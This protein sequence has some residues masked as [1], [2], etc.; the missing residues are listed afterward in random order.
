MRLEKLWGR[1]TERG[2]TNSWKTRQLWSKEKLLLSKIVQENASEKNESYWTDGQNTALSCTITRLTKLPVRWLLGFVLWSCPEVRAGLKLSPFMCLCASRNLTG[3]T[4]I[5][6]CRLFLSLVVWSWFQLSA[7]RWE[8]VVICFHRRTFELC[9][10]CIGHN[11]Y[12]V[13]LCKWYVYPD[14]Y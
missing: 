3:V 9:F 5:F 8:T 6:T 13:C 11:L 10:A 7:F 12:T 14:Q 1:T 4:V 2:H